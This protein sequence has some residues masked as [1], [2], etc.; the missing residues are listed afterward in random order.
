MGKFVALMAWIVI[1]LTFSL[2]LANWI[3]YTPTTNSTSDTLHF[4]VAGPCFSGDFNVA[5][6][7][8]DSIEI[9]KGADTEI[10]YS[11][12][13]SDAFFT[14]IIPL[15]SIT[16]GLVPDQNIKFSL[17]EVPIGKLFSIPVTEYLTGIPSWIAGIGLELDSNISVAEISGL[18]ENNIK[19]ELSDLRWTD[20]GTREVHI[21]T[22]D[23]IGKSPVM[24][25]F[26][27]SS[28]LKIKA[29]AGPIQLFDYPLIQLNS[30]TKPDISTAIM[31]VEPDT[32]PYFIAVLIGLLIPTSVIYCPEWIE[33][34]I[35]RRL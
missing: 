7:W 21:R 3:V 26:T 35:S 28:S 31:T 24:T 10:K 14:I 25:M 1:S 27:F 22:N 29:N 5:I 18:Q 19:T 11:L 34:I 9:P 13:S 8:T 23:V 2:I 17:D 33:W 4:N 30:I 20:W 32:S 12:E 16:F 15:R 6:V